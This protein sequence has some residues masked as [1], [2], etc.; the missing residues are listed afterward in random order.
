MLNEYFY[1]PFSFIILYMSFNYYPGLFGICILNRLIFSV[2]R[3]IRLYDSDI[4]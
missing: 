3:W 4:Q 2:V 1:A